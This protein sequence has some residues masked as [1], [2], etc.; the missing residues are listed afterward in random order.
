MMMMMM[1]MTMALTTHP[2]TQLPPSTH[3]LTQSPPPPPSD[4][5]HHSEPSQHATSKRMAPRDPLDFS[6]VGVGSNSTF[7][8]TKDS[9]APGN[10]KTVWQQST[11]SDY[12]PALIYEA[13]RP[14]ARDLISDSTKGDPPGPIN[15]ITPAQPPLS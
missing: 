1:M 11:T 15:N 2:L 13:S 14:V 10:K 5:F 4:Y 6:R 9:N 8:E 12:F 3:P 7:Y